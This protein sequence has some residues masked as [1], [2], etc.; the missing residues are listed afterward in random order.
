MKPPTTTP[1]ARTGNKS[2]TITGGKQVR[3]QKIIVYG[4]GGIGKSELCSLL[5]QAG[6][7]PLFFDVDNGTA[8]QEVSRVEGLDTFIDVRSAMQSPDLRNAGFDLFVVD[9]ITKVEELAS[10]YVVANYKDKKGQHVT[11][12]DGFDFGQGYEYRHNEMLKF[13]GDCDDV[14]RSGISVVLIA[15]ETTA[16]VPNP[17]GVDFIRW[18]PRLY[19][20]STPGG[21]CDTRA[22]FKEW[23][24]HMLFIGYD[25]MV[26][27]AGKAKGGG[28]RMIYTSELPTHMAKTRSLTRDVPY[29]K[30]SAL[31]W[32]NIFNGEQ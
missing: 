22:V 26:N 25:V 30:G 5:T 29:E 18:E 2:F 16:K 28:S 15:Q 19:R 21:K 17:A 14:V 27:D 13:L 6:R 9:T 11:S 1:A 31:V 12:I 23:A 3:A 24:D 4:P 20:P 32:N 7:K 8:F 10:P